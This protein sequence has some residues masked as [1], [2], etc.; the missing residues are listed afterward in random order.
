MSQLEIM[1]SYIEATKA[2]IEQVVPSTD[3]EKSDPNVALFNVAAADGVI[4]GMNT[5]RHGSLLALSAAA[6]I[7]SWATA[8][9]TDEELQNIDLKNYDKHP[10]LFLPK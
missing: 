2:K 9:E 7:F 3:K 1:F 6:D 5:A 10:F 4:N 8:D